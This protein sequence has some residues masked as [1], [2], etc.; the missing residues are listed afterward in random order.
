MTTKISRREFL[1]YLTNLFLGWGIL[2]Q[3][4]RLGQ[5][6]KIRVSHNGLKEAKYYKSADTLAG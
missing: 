4:L 6:Q 3:H 1:K 2:A 5:E